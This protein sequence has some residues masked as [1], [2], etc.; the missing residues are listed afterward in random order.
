VNP[1]PATTCAS[2]RKALHQ[3]HPDIVTIS[4]EGQFIK[5]GAV[6]ELQEQM[7]FR[8]REGRRRVF[9][10][11]EADRMNAPAANALLK[12]L[13]EPSAGNILLLTT[14]RPHALPLTILSRCQ[15]L[16]FTPLPREEV[17]RYLRERESLDGQTATA[18]AAS[19][20]GSI[21]RA[22]EMRRGDWLGMRTG[23]SNISPGTT[24]PIRSNG[25][26]SPA[27]SGRSARDL[28]RLEIL[29]TCYRDAMVLRETGDAE[30]LIF[31]DRTTLIRTISERLSEAVFSATSPRSRRRWRRSTR[32]PIR[33]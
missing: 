12:T 17:I 16:R 24:R 13:E 14:S 20:G 1:P 3:N 19:S 29:R 21:G 8:P 26:P 18:L 9:V 31:P 11:P 7:K 25:L 5:I 33:R 22:L 27:V 30:R 28:A 15:H 23:S 6:K 10:M 32:T 4:A 2:C